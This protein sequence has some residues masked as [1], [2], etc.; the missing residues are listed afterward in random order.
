MP[1]IYTGRKEQAN[2]T[3]SG[4]NVGLWVCYGMVVCDLENQ[5]GF[6]LHDSE[7][8]YFKEQQ[9]KEPLSSWCLLLLGNTAEQH[10]TCYI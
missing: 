3:S 10:H 8:W 7:S 9:Q 1:P 2:M 4:Q 5:I 6:L